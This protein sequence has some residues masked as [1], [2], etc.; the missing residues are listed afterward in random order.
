[1]YTYIC[2]IHI[3]MYVCIYVYVC[4]YVCIY[5]YIYIGIG[6]QA[7]KLV[8][9]AAHRPDVRGPRVWLLLEV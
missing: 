2:S 6:L 3:H 1:M 9:D 5:I 4:M 7:A 8:T